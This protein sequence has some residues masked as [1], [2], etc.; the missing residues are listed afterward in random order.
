[1][2]EGSRAHP[3]LRFGRAE[4]MRAERPAR[5]AYHSGITFRI[6]ANNALNR[7]AKNEPGWL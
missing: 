7:D 4:Q 3:W 1:M 6:I 5:G 2:D